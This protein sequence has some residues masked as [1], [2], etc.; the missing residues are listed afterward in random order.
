MKYKSK[1]D[2]RFKPII[3]EYNKFIKKTEK[4]GTS[5]PCY[6]RFVLVGIAEV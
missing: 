6:R 1:I 3:L 2:K 4:N 5:H